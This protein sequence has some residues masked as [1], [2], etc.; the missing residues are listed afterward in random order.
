M[1]EE[2]RTAP[3]DHMIFKNG[4]AELVAD[5]NT[6]D[7]ERVLRSAVVNGYHACD[8]TIPALDDPPRGGC[9][10]W[11]AEAKVLVHIDTGA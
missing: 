7:L 9:R 8:E 1:N 10:C 3:L 2:R 6:A 4:S 11:V 5:S